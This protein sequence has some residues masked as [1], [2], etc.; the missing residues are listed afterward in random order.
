VRPDQGPRRLARSPVTG[1]TNLA[2]PE[3]IQEE[4]LAAEKLAMRRPVPLWLAGRP[5]W[6]EGII[7]T[8]N[9]AW[10]RTGQPP[11]RID[12]AQSG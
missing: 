2:L 5:G 4:C 7:A 10:R 9:W 1:R 12:Q 8:L 11:I 6:A 3:L